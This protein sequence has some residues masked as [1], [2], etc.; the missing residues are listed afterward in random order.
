LLFAAET[1]A[2]MPCIM[3]LQTVPETSTTTHAAGAPGST[4]ASRF[5]RQHPVRAAGR[6]VAATGP[7]HRERVQLRVLK[8]DDQGPGVC[9]IAAAVRRRVRYAASRCSYRR[10]RGTG[11]S[12]GVVFV[13]PALQVRVL[14]FISSSPLPSPLLAC[15]DFETCQLFS[16]RLVMTPAASK[17]TLARQIP[18]P[19]AIPSSRVPLRQLLPSLTTS[20]DSWRES[21]GRWQCTDTSQHLLSRARPCE[22]SRLGTLAAP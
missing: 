1:E 10:S 13:S 15:R 18:L 21:C 12:N 9:L 5:M 14:Y 6:C 4:L 17:F 2:D 8:Y 22:R 11:V 16:H 3:V 19:H 7:V 20:V